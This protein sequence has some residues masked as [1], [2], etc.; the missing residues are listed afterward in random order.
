MEKE[1][2]RWNMI[3]NDIWDTTLRKA[4]CLPDPLAPE[5]VEKMKAESRQFFEGSPQDNYLGAPDKYHKLMNEKQWEA[6]GG[7]EGLFE[8]TM[9]PVQHE[10]YR[11]GEAKVEFKADVAKRKAEKANAGKSA[12]PVTSAALAPTP[13]ATLAIPTT[14]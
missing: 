5:I 10:A 12:V 14:P 11:S 4:G 7:K 2:A 13:T 3:I 8:Y 1:R 9:Y 6:G